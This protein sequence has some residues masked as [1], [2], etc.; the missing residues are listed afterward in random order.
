MARLKIESWC[1]YQERSQKE[2]RDKLYGYGLHQND[3]EQI[4]TELI[5]NN[6]LNEERFAIAFAGGKFRIKKWGR[7]KIKLELRSRQVSD[8]CIKKALQ[9]IPDNEYISTLEKILSQKAK[10]V[11]EPN[12]IKKHYKLIQYA[13][14]RGF[15]KDLIIDVLN[16]IEK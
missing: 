1:A 3:V 5:G 11:S 2:T 6:F 13:A 7:I 9:Q 15:E 16:E 4:I 10:L 12:K 8:Y 14:S